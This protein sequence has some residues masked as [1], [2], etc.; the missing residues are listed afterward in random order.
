MT[1]SDRAPTA[2][3]SAKRN[4]EA[5]GIRPADSSAV[6]AASARCVPLQTSSTTVVMAST[7]PMSTPSGLA[8]T[9]RET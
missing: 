4:V 6:R 9:I 3:N 1:P 7:L 5:G 2:A 8:G